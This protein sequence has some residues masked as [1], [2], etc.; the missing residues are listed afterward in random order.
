M[1]VVFVSHRVADAAPA[2]KLADDI[3]A[4][5]HDVRLDETDLRVGD[6][7]VEWMNAGLADADYVVLCYSAHGVESKWIMREWASALARQLQ[8]AGVKLLPVV[9][10][11]GDAPAIL[12][13]L[14][15]ADLTKDWSRGVAQLLRAIR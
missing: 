9:L 14:K 5:G 8:G 11:G 10:T 2:E 3:R 12:A 7:I 1:A 4:A 6:S 13:D 15:T